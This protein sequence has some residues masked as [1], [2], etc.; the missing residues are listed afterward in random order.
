M[1]QFAEEPFDEVALS[2]EVPIDRSLH[3]AIRTGRDVR[4][5]A[6]CSD[7]I[8]D[9]SGVVSTIGDD[10]A[11]PATVE[12]EWNRGLVGSLPG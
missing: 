4:G 11:G 9:G 12:E 2:V 10:V 8:E 3:T 7:Q 6:V 1:L 5:P